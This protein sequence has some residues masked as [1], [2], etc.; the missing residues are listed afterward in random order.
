MAAKTSAIENEI[1]RNVF[2][3]TVIVA[4]LGYFVDI[5]DLILFNIIKKSS[6]L[7]IG[8]TASSVNDVGIYLYNLQ[9][10]GMLV[11]GIVWGILGDKKGRMSALFLT[12]LIYSLANIANG[13]VHTIFQY[14]ILRFI[15]GFGL[16][17][18]LGLGITLVSEVMTK[19]K[20][21]W[22]TSIVAGVGIL[23]A[24]LAYLVSKLG[25]QQAYWFGGGLGLVLLGLRIYIHESGM[26]KKVKEQVEV[27][28]GNFFMVFTS[29]KQ[30]IKYLLCILVGLP[31]WFV[32]GILIANSDQFAEVM[33]IKGGIEVGKSIMFHYSGAA[34]G[35]LVTGWLCQVFHSRKKSVNIALISIT[36]FTIAF[37]ACNNASS[38]LFYLIMFLLGVGQGYWGVFVTIAS[39]QFGTNIRST[40][41]TTVPNFVRGS[42]VLMTMW[43]KGMKPSLGI[44]ESAMIVGAVVMVLAFIATNMMQETFGKDLD[45]NEA[46]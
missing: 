9:M 20:R 25:W 18:E 8:V 29:K 6:L 22:G 41:T 24:V 44:L 34:I 16:A 42:L 10:F 21:G 5:Y 19:E 35:S 46:A 2:N 23:G 33:K 12:I 37:F 27:A 1:T 11:G 3:I 17:G 32:I 26:F 36:V 7:G 30:F 40:I 38:S 43:W 31:V 45:Y 14:E 13:F 4:A 28:R 39:E 15:A